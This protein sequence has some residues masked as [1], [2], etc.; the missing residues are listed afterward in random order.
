MIRAVILQGR[1]KFD[2]SGD[3]ADLKAETLRMWNE[4]QMHTHQG[5]TY[6]MQGY[7]MADGQLPAW[8]IDEHKLIHQIAT[9]ANQDKQ[10]RD[11]KRGK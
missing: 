5:I 9:A 11:R 8:K 10:K 4:Y 1:T 2:M 3:D 6:A 7:L